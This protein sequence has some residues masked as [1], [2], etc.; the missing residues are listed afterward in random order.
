MTPPASIAANRPLVLLVEDYAA[1]RILLE[2]FLQ[3]CG[4]RVLTLNCGDDV[5]VTPYETLC[6]AGYALVDDSLP[7]NIS[8][9]Q[10][11]AMLHLI[12]PRL[13]IFP[14]SGRPFQAWELE[15]MEAHFERCLPKPFGLPELL[16][17]LQSPP[18]PP[19]PP[20][21]PPP[22]TP[23]ANIARV[24]STVFF[25]LLVVGLLGLAGYLF[26]LVPDFQ[27]VVWLLTKQL[28]SNSIHL[29]GQ[30]SAVG[31]V[32]LV[33]TGLL[34]AIT[35]GV[36]AFNSDW[37]TRDGFAA[38]LFWLLTEAGVVAGLTGLGLIIA[39]VVKMGC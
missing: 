7:G 39:A 25:W 3:K 32:A 13:R 19:S 20:K 4:F 30:G 35:V 11:V 33:L 38:L 23:R 21:T 29:L 1:I 24:I 14:I 10:T 28:A 36:F 17:A 15:L 18:A 16:A 26:S 5:L 2:K 12:N 6:E 31:L 8:G 37:H 9:P 22:A 34:L 27:H